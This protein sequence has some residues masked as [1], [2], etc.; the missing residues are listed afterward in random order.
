MID[1]SKEQPEYIKFG[2]L[3]LTKVNVSSNGKF[4]W[5][6]KNS[7]QQFQLMY[8]KFVDEFSMQ[9]YNFYKGNF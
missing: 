7:H 6:Y 3:I 1:F 4:V 8:Y 2:D 9:V 5:E